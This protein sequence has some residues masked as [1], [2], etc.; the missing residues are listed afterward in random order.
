M[1]RPQ[2]ETVEPTTSIDAIETIL[3]RDGCVIIRDIFTPAAVDELMD[4]LGSHLE[5]RLTGNHEFVGQ[6]T[7]RLPTLITKSSRVGNFFADD[8][9]YYLG[10]QRFHHRQWGYS[11]RAGQPSLGA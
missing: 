11:D 4:Y 6:H 7:K 8:A 9:G 3:N 10:M 2:I 1:S 5:R